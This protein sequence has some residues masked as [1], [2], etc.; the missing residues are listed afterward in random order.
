M[1]MVGK[2]SGPSRKIKKAKSGEVDLIWGC[3]GKWKYGQRSK[4]LGLSHYDNRSL[5]STKVV[6]VSKQCHVTLRLKCET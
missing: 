4:G 6:Q 3:F 1:W 2:V 5:M